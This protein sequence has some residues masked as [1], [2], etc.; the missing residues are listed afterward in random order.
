MSRKMAI[1]A[2]VIGVLVNVLITISTI[3]GIAFLVQPET[4]Q[5]ESSVSSVEVL[6]SGTC[7]IVT[8]EPQSGCGVDDPPVGGQYGDLQI[9]G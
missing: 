3:A 7:V 1:A 2:I 9:V 4:D 5:R 6:S 8:R